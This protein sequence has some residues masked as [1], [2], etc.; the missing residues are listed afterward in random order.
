MLVVDAGQ[1]AILTGIEDSD[2]LDFRFPEGIRQVHGVEVGGTRAVAR[3]AF[4]KDESLAAD[5]ILPPD[6]QRQSFHKE[7]VDINVQRVEYGLIHGVVETDL[8]VGFRVQPN[9]ELHCA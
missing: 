1:E 3:C 5:Q 7:L 8:L 2:G 6:F 4:E 9:V